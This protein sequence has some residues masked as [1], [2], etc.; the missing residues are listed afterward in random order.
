M[1]EALDATAA[2]M[3]RLAAAHGPQSVA[4]TQSSPSTTAIGESA[5]FLHRLMKAVGTPN[6]VWALDMCGWGRGYATRYAYGV[7]SVAT[8]SAGGAM[9]DIENSGC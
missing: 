6:L 4:F 7:A 1:D 9:E 2:A 8:G 5:P 3:K